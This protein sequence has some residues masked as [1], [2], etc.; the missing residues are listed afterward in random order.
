MD[1]R[2]LKV[3][4]KYLLSL[5]SS[6]SGKRS[7]ISFHINAKLAISIIKIMRI[8]F[9]YRSGTVNSNTVNSKFNLIQIFYEVSVNIFSIISCLKCTVNSNFHLIQSKTLPTNDFE[10][11][12]PDLYNFNAAF[13]C[14]QFQILLTS[15]R[16]KWKT[17]RLFLLVQAKLIFR[18]KIG[19]PFF[20][21]IGLTLWQCKVFTWNLS[22]LVLPV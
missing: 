1:H 19:T 8:E 6:V 14:V 3:K 10:L 5:I 13:K 16:L 11:T 18:V 12:V 7:E 20:A 9:R 2:R 22:Q 4:I 21:L 17:L 15:A